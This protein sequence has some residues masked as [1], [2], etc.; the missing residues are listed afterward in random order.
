M[1]SLLTLLVNIVGQKLVDSLVSA[2]IKSLTTWV[3]D[4]NIREMDAGNV[5]HDT[6]RYYLLKA[7]SEAETNEQRQI[8]SI[9]LARIHSG[10]LPDS[11]DQGES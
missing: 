2:L 1:G 7:I 9:S 10:R 5:T 4:K 8:L 6:E 3:V 11:D